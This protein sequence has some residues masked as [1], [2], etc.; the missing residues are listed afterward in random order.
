MI[1]IVDN[2]SNY[3]KR[4]LYFL[5]HN[6]IPYFL[7]SNKKEDIVFDFEVVKGVILTGGPKTPEE[8]DDLVLN[9]KIIERTFKK[10]VPLLGF[11]LSHEIIAKHFGG[12]ISYFPK[13]VTGMRYSNQLLE[14]SLFEGVSKEFIVRKNHYACVSKMPENF[15]LIATSK[16]CEIEVMKHREKEIYALQGHPET[17]EGDGVRIM[18]NFLKKCGYDLK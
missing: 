14:S 7:I 6:K 10:N 3:I 15:D 18:I 17:L 4:F 1:L 8:R 12:K 11:C 16:D 5:D 9:H 13:R 2:Q